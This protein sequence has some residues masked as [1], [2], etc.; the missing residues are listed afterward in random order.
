MLIPRSILIKH[1]QNDVSKLTLI[2]CRSTYQSVTRC[3]NSCD[4]LI[5]I[6]DR[7]DEV[8]VEHLRLQRRCTY[9][10]DTSKCDTLLQKLLVCKIVN[11]RLDEIEVEYIDQVSL[12]GNYF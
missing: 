8:E 1:A 7:V 2:L 11:D 9:L 6:W 4:R 10:G 12:D 3:C 5:S